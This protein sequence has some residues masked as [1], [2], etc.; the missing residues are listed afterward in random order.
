[1]IKRIMLLAA[2]L[3]LIA[4]SSLFAADPTPSPSPAKEAA[5]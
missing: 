3:G 5:T 1:M 4:D 2:V